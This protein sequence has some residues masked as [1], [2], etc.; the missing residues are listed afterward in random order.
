MGTRLRSGDRREFSVPSSSGHRPDMTHR[1]MIF[2]VASQ[3]LLHQGIGR[4]ALLA[5]GMRREASQSLLHQ[6][7]GRTPDVAPRCRRTAVSVPSSSGHRPDDVDRLNDLFRDGLSP[8]FIR[9]SAGRG[10][11]GP[12]G[13]DIKSQS[14]LHQG[15]GRTAISANIVNQLRVS[16]PSSSGH[17]PDIKSSPLW[18]VLDG[19][20]SLLHQGIGRTFALGAIVV[21]VLSQ[22]L[23][24]QGIGRTAHCCFVNPVPERLSPF[25]IRASAGP[26]M[27]R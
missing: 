12:L 4:T 21:L 9:A 3:S 5:H 18:Q 11:I 8:F 27:V 15:I 17:R 20:Q 2:L 6:G 24:H 23:L 16:V 19:S 26:V 22:S 10:E 1:Q 7:I 13:A 25:F 14:L